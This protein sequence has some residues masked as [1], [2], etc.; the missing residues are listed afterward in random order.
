MSSE[1]MKNSFTNCPPCLLAEKGGKLSGKGGKLSSWASKMLY[2]PPGAVYIA[3]YKER[4]DQSD[5]W[6]L[7]VQLWNYTKLGYNVQV[8][9]VTI[10]VTSTLM[11]TLIFPVKHDRGNDPRY[12]LEP[13]SLFFNSE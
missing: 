9:F 8:Y 4:L 11:F 12:G 1:L 5:C 10:I 3:S 6:K 13:I 7:F 2:K